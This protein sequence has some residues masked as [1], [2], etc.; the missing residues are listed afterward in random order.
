MIRRSTK[1]QTGRHRK[2]NEENGSRATRKLD[3]FL[4]DRNRDGGNASR[5]GEAETG[6]NFN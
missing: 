6:N 3:L 4:G 2:P 1:K 5:K